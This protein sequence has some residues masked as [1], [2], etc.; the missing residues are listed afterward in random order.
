MIQWIIS[1][2]IRYVNSLSGLEMC[3]AMRTCQC[4]RD[5]T[6]YFLAF[7][8]GSMV[9]IHQKIQQSRIVTRILPSIFFFFNSIPRKS[10]HGQSYPQIWIFR[11]VT[12][13]DILRNIVE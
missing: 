12:K 5:I 6:D 11:I 2:E 10:L 8:V 4:A 9:I 1:S 3:G 7:S 13:T